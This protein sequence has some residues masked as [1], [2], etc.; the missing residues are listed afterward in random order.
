MALAKTTRP[1]SVAAIL[2]PRLFKRLDH[3]QRRATWVWSPP[4]AGKTVLIA[5]YLAT[6][7]LNHL[8]FQVDEGDSDLSSFFYFLGVAAPKRRRP[9]PLLTPEFRQNVGIFTRNFFRELYGRL[10]TPFVIVFDDYQEVPVEA[11]LNQIMPVVLAELP[12]QGRAIFLSRNEPPPSFAKLRADQAVELLDYSEIRF[13]EPEAA[14]L[15]QK[16]SPGKW[17]KSKITEL[18]KHSDGWAV[19]LVLL[20]EQLRTESRG[21]PQKQ[22]SQ[23]LFDYFADEIFSK[24]DAKTKDVLLQTAYLPQVSVE[25]AERLTGQSEA[26]HVLATQHKRNY[27]TYLRR[28]PEPTYEYHPLFREFFLA[29]AERQYSLERLTEIRLEA[30]KLLESIR[31][32]Y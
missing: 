13:T 22:I 8:W 16:L 7:K 18:Y 6:R 31:T 25:L 30:A 1:T 9:M 29:Q 3:L 24:A 21:L 10:K 28:G 14:G 20:L 27:F 5:S 11:E 2:R 26:G 15:I 17:S 12:G 4:G 19:G 32:R 23:V